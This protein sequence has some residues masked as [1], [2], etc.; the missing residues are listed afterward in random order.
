MDDFLDQVCHTLAAWDVDSLAT[1]PPPPEELTVELVAELRR[2]VREG[3]KRLRPIYSIWGWLA[4]GG[5]SRPQTH[6]LLV[7][8]GAALELLHLFALVQDD[9]MDRSDHRRGL[10]TLHLTAAEAHR[11][12]GSLGDPVLFGDSA[13]TLLGDLALSEA[14]LLVAANPAPVRALWRLMTVELVHGQLYDL[15]HAASR[16][17]RIEM[18]RAI[19][20]L[21]TGRYT[22]TRPLQLG[23]LVAGADDDLALRLGAYG[24]LVG[25]AF[26]IRDDILGVWGDPAT[27]GKPVGDD[28][29]S[30][31]PTVLLAMAAE[32]VPESGRALMAA[33]NAGT[34]DDDGVH[35]LRDGLAAWGVLDR[36]EAMI[37][38]LV[39]EASG[40]LASTPV[41]PQARAALDGLANRVA[42]RCS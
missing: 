9:V 1:S 25:D 24:D 3:G 12:L 32:R 16:D 30:A 19:A 34:L 6:A 15:T 22:V 14:C 23:A 26:A 33:C 21:K 18:T 11:R 35:A 31:K 41:D 40:L 17:R 39:T 42:W 10:P 7:E 27:T 29:R 8:I 2:R 28:L 4:A 20:R 38:E 37:A 13:A 5:Q 36:A